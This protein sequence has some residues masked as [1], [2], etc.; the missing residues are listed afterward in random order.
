MQKHIRQ[1][2]GFPEETDRLV[3]NAIEDAEAGDPLLMNF[4]DEAI[5]NSQ[6]D[7]SQNERSSSP[8]SQ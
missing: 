6:N 2:E 1:L 8:H 3:V 5:D 4:S 7:N